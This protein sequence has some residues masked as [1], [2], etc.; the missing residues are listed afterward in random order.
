MKNLILI[1][2]LLFSISVFASSNDV[3]IEIKNDKLEIK[4]DTIYKYIILNRQKEKVGQ[5]YT[6]SK[7][8]LDISLLPKG[9]YIVEFYSNKKFIFRKKIKK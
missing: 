7:N 1:F 3:K 2:L 4:A 6:T 8:S 9:K 5:S